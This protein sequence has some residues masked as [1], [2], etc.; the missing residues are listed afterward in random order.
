MKNVTAYY[1]VY[2]VPVFPFFHFSD[3]MFSLPWILVQ[4]DM[5]KSDKVNS[6]IT[7]LYAPSNLSYF[8]YN[9]FPYWQVR[10]LWTVKWWSEQRASIQ[11]VECRLVVS[12][13]ARLKQPFCIHWSLFKVG[14]PLLISCSMSL[15]TKL[16]SQLLS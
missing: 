8:I 1:Y 16:R 14:Q 2:S 6:L 5:F 11:E 10:D 13:T 3:M 4:W 12:S 15:Q 9:I 7:W